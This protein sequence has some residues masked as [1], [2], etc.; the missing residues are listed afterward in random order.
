MR[1]Y[2]G[3]TLEIARPSVAASR[4]NLDF[5]RGFYLTSYEEQAAQWALR[6][7]AFED[8]LAMVNEYEFDDDLASLNVL[9]F[10]GADADWVDFVCDCRRGSVRY[11]EY[12]LIVGGV[13]DDKVYFAVDMYLRGLWD[14]PTTLDALKYYKVN[15]QWC[16]VSQSALD[17]HVAFVRSWEVSKHAGD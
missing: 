9:R 8:K 11:R 4:G 16:F 15:D 14:M 1:L 7:S 13:A 2:H 6:K 3:S 10:D 12:D 17:E 5:G